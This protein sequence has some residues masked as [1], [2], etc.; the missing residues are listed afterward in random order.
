MLPI[1]D[2][3]AAACDG[4]EVEEEEEEATAEEAAAE[5]E[6]EEGFFTRPYH[7]I[8]A[9]YP[10]HSLESQRAAHSSKDEADSPEPQKVLK[11]SVETKRKKQPESKP[12]ESKE[13]AKRV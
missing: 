4:V 6:E 10:L 1:V 7:S 9:S 5:E 11:K 12:Q 8:D 3:G 2:E 13:A